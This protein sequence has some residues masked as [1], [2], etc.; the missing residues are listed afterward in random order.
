MFRDEISVKTE[1]VKSINNIIDK[2]VNQGS[3]IK[4]LKKYFNKDS[5]LTT[6]LGDLRFGKS[7]LKNP[8]L[9]F[10]NSKLEYKNKVRQYLNEVIVDRLAY[11][12]DNKNESMIMKP[13][14]FEDY[15]HINEIKLPVV[16]LDEILDDIGFA[17]GI[18]KKA[19]TNFFKT[20]EDYIDLVDKKKHHFKINDISGDIMGNNRVTFDAI[21]FNN[22]EINLIID[23]VVKYSIGEFYSQLPDTLNIFDIEIKPMS[24]INK[25]D[26]KEIFKNLLTFNQ[27]IETITSI[28]GFE[29][30]G[31]LNDF[32][33]WSKK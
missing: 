26:L 5:N 17:K 30:N 14:N 15:M 33:I 2:Y 25:N 23:N 29:Y 1:I 8:G 19:L 27:V 9:D 12:K 7:N 13:K 16:R 6:L 4:D 22:N 21:I 20:H 31:Q 28:T 32:Y 18:H 10:F 24:L 11:E 3:S